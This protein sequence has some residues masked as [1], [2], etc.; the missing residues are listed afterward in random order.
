M[1]SLLLLH[2]EE[3]NFKTSSTTLLYF[4]F[5]LRMENMY[6]KCQHKY[7]RKHQ[8]VKIELQYKN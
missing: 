2:S 3:C 6:R 4:P 8:V 5:K 1:D 7:G